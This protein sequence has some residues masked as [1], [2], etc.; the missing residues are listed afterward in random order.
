MKAMVIALL[1]VLLGGERAQAQLSDAQIV[2]RLRLSPAPSPQMPP[3][4]RCELY[5]RHIII[6][7]AAGA[8]GG[9]LLTWTARPAIQRVAMVGGALAGGGYALRKAMRAG[10]R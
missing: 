1:L 6:M 3:A 4:A 9:Y 8:A 2:S 5:A 10:C 7:G